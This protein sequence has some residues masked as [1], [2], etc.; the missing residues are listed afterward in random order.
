MVLS[1]KK[2]QLKEKFSPQN[3]KP[4]QQMSSAEIEAYNNARLNLS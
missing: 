2:D 3:N 1:I 4:T